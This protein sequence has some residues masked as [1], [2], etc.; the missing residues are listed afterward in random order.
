MKRNPVREA[1]IASAIVGRLTADKRVGDQPVLAIVVGNDA[2]LVGRV[3]TL[4]QRD[5]VEF[6]VRGTPGVG[7]VNTDELEV[8][9]LVASVYVRA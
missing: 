3:Q 8:E 6:I 9:E 4:E 7:R 1:V 2:Y 5:V